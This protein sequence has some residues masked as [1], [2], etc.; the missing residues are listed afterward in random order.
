MDNRN[1]EN[2]FGRRLASH[3][4]I[5][6]APD[7][8]LSNGAAPGGPTVLDTPNQPGDLSFV[9]DSLLADSTYGPLID[10]AHIG[11]SGLSLGGLTTLLSTFHPR[12]RDQRIIA[13]LPMAG[14]SCMFTAPFFAQSVPL[15]LVQGD[16][17][18]IAPP[19][20][21]S[22]RS[23]PLAQAPKEL[24]LLKAGSHTAFAGVA[25]ILDPTMN[26]DRLGCGELGSVSVTGFGAL[27]SEADGI[28]Q[29]P[30]RLSRAVHR[31]AGRSVAERRSPARPDQG[32]RAGVLRQL[33]A[34]KQRRREVPGRRA[35]VGESGSHRSLEVNPRRAL[36]RE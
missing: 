17:D 28:S 35:G 16:A 2:Y 5:V 26:Y 29:D 15:L 1:G 9:I 24:A 6:A 22:E 7:Y 25:S 31:H 21:N 13:A 4:F 27:G 12:L 3:G 11:A 33:A 20:A 14:V 36:S 19:D 34:R 30:Q 32:H 10:A 18:L 8:P 23:F